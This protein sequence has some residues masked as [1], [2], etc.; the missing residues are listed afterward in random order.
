[1]LIFFLFIVTYCNRAVALSSRTRSVCCELVSLFINKSGA[2]VLTGYPTLANVLFFSV[3]SSFFF[4][5]KNQRKRL[6][7]PLITEAIVS[8]EICNAPH[9]VKVLFLVNVKSPP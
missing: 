6:M 8:F 2:T 1:M 5:F 7:C 9:K 4:P 3:S